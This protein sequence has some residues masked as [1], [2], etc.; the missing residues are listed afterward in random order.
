M[1]GTDRSLFE[2]LG[3]RA[4]FFSVSNGHAVREN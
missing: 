1:T 2:T 4:Q 3:T